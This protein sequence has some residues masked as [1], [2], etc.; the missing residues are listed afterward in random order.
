M[1]AQVIAVRSLV[2]ANLQGGNLTRAAMPCE[3]QWGISCLFGGLF[4]ILAA[5]VFTFFPAFLDIFDYPWYI[6][7][8]WFWFLLG[9]VM[10]LLGAI[11]QCLGMQKSG[12]W[13]NIKAREA[14]ESMDGE[15]PTP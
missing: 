7:L 12:R 4:I 9:C 10:T 15:V 14:E 5:G 13:H 1:G 6:D 8:C 11:Y 3:C 2:F